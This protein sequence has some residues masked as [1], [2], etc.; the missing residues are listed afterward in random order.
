LP[1]ICCIRLHPL[2][3]LLSA[4]KELILPIK[5]KVKVII[6]KM[7]GYGRL[8][9]ELKGNPLL[10]VRHADS[11]GDSPLGRGRVSIY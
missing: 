7:D 10:P 11:P 3:E 2:S 8:M 5:D 6:F 4:R 1:V 9:A